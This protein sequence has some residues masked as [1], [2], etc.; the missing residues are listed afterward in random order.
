[1]RRARKKLLISIM[2]KDSLLPADSPTTTARREYSPY[3]EG[4]SEDAAQLISSAR[5]SGVTAIYY[6]CTAQYAMAERR[7]GDDMFYYVVKGSGQISSRGKT[8]KVRPGDCAHFARGVLHA[9]CANA[10][11]PFEVIALHYTAKVFGALTIPQ[12]LGFPD[13][14]RLGPASPFE[15]MLTISCR[16]FALRPVG[17]E[18]GLE[19]LVLRMLLYL[20]RNCGSDMQ[21]PFSASKWRELERVLPALELL[22]AQISQPVDVQ[23]LA[24]VCHLSPPQFRRVFRA[25]LGSAPT[26]YSRLRRMEEAALLLRGGD[27]TIAVI[28]SRVGYADPAFFAHSFKKIMGISPGKYRA[29]SGF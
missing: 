25:A 29:Q 1:M 16:E 12:I 27:E 6:R 9:A 22:R 20:M 10:R 11:D 18:C 4:I 21:A 2:R 5:I 19:A 15:E 17:W 26:E 13:V 24:R 23:V 14:F 8:V 3:N 28:A 7:I